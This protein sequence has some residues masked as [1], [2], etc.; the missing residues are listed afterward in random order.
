MARS[1]PSRYW[2]FVRDRGVCWLCR[3]PCPL[4]EGSLDHVV[5]RSRKGPDC[6]SN[7]RYAHRLCNVKRGGN[8]IPSPH[9]FLW[10]D[11]IETDI[12]LMRRGLRRYR[13]WWS[14]VGCPPE[15]LDFLQGGPFPY[16]TRQLFGS[17]SA[18]SFAVD[19]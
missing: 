12:E 6:I 7:L 17:V 16:P 2:A 9:D 10:H 1:V 8:V 11:F 3:R 19:L 5:P 4:R 18:S 14:V 15:I 13:S